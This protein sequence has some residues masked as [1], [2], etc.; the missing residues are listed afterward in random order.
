M[1][2]ESTKRESQTAETEI[3]RPEAQKRWFEPAIVILMALTTISTTWCSY[4][5]S[6]WSGESSGFQT[7]TDELLRQALAMHS[8]A[9]Q[10]EAMHAD[11]FMSMIN[12][13]LTGNEK[14]ADFYVARF[15]PELKAA[16]VKWMALNPFEN[17]SA[18]AHPFVPG[19]YVPRYDKEVKQEEDQAALYQKQSRVS[20]K[21]AAG[22]LSNT[23]LL[24]AVLFFAGTAGKFVQPHVRVGSFIFA[25]AFFL[26]AVVRLLLLPIA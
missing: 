9:N 26:Y 2:D 25:T 24:A 18:P 19:L 7:Q 3:A 12:A 23:V 16:Y 4:E 21:N 1:M 22:Y 13:K 5:S 20:G 11:M 6:R 17:A 14:L 8:E 10:L 15:P